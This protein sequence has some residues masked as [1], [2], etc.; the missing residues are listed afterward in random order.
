MVRSARVLYA[1]GVFQFQQDHSSSNDF[2]LVKEW[3]S[4]QADVER[5]D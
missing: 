5:I 4:W 1:D 3:L 2:L